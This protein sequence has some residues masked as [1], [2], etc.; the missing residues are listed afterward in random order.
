M[1]RLIIKD[2]KWLRMQLASI[3]LAIYAIILAIFD[4]SYLWIGPVIFS[5]WLSIEAIRRA[6]KLKDERNT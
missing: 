2:K 3:L 1:N 5:I 6:K 4:K